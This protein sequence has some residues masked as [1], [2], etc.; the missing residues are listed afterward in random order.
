MTMQNPKGES[1]QEQFKEEFKK[2]T[3]QLITTKN[4]F[5]F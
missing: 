5:G 2:S 4:N 1:K 3:K